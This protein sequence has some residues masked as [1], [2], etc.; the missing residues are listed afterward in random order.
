MDASASQAD[1]RT[2]RSHESEKGSEVEGVR[3]RS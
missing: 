2:R 3:I 1:L